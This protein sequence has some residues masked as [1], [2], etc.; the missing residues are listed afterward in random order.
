M[1]LEGRCS[2][3]EP[4][5]IATH[6]MACNVSKSSPQVH[7]RLKQPKLASHFQLGC[8]ALFP[9]VWAV[10]AWLHA[11]HIVEFH[12]VARFQETLEAQ[13]TVQAATGSSLIATTGA[14][15]L[16]DMASCLHLNG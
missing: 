16:L 5:S 10:C 7:W 6:G 4:S 14:S 9:A 3:V 11:E 13:S 12:C 2:P 15:G 1:V 8:F